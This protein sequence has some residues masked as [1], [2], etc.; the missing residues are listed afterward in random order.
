VKLRTPFTS[1]LYCGRDHRGGLY[2]VRR[3]G[4]SIVPHGLASRMITW[5]VCMPIPVFFSYRAWARAGTAGLPLSFW[6]R[7]LAPITLLTIV[8]LCLVGFAAE[9]PRARRKRGEEMAAQGRCGACGY[10]LGSVPPGED[11]CRLCPE[12]GS[13]WRGLGGKGQ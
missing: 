2:D 4:S 11:G 6:E 8:I 3:A 9:L 12:C 13:A 10:G 5:A 7:W 1:Y